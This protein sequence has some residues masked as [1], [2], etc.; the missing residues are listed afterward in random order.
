MNESSKKQKL[1]DL[2]DRL[3]R[4]GQSTSDKITEFIGSWAFIVFFVVFVLVWVGVNLY[5]YAETFDPY[6]FILLN[7]TLSCLAAIQAPLI[8]M[9]QNR[10][11][12]NDRERT[13]L[14][15]YVNR[16]AEKEIA[17]MQKDLDDIKAL[18]RKETVE[19]R[20]KDK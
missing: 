16:R 8:M 18:I 13:E 19:R 17:D 2:Y 14:D 20:K 1:K 7:L 9:S 3:S 15:Y 10:Q 12:Q 4:A 11:M 5:A 6:P